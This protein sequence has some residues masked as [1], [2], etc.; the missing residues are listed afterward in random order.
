MRDGGR[1]GAGLNLTAEVRASATVEGAASGVLVHI[2]R[3]VWAQLAA[4]RAAAIRL[5]RWSG[6]PSLDIF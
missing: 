1:D 3:R 2:V 5:A 4:A 6:N